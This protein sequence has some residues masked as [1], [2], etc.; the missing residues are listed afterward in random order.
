MSSQITDCS[1]EFKRN[2][3]EQREK[4]MEM[5]P[6]LLWITLEYLV[7]AVKVYKNII[8]CF[9]ELI[10]NCAKCTVFACWRC[11]IKWRWALEKTF[12]WLRPS[13]R[14]PRPQ[15][16][17][18]NTEHKQ[19]TPSWASKSHHSV[20][21][22]QQYLALSQAWNH[23]FVFIVYMLIW[24]FNYLMLMNLKTIL[25]SRLAPFSETYLFTV[26][27]LPSF[28]SYTIGESCSI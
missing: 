23:S 25:Y 18:C 26:T 1:Y 28:M 6:F 9:A 4:L 13:L 8:I 20:S 27:G 17:D 10:V 21:F 15:P 7:S 19:C 12:T 2:P 16:P 3:E 24:M 22:I 14:P 11:I 5:F